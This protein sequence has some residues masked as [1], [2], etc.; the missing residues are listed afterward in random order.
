MSS[1]ALAAMLANNPMTTLPSSAAVTRPA[2]SQMQTF[3]FA[4]ALTQLDSPVSESKAVLKSAEARFAAAAATEKV[5][6]LKL[7]V[8]QR[9]LELEDLQASDGAASKVV[10]KAERLLQK[11]VA[12]LEKAE[13]DAA[14]KVA[15]AKAAMT[16]EQR[17][18]E[19]AAAKA[20]ATAAAKKR[21][22]EKK[23]VA[24]MQNKGGYKK[25]GFAKGGTKK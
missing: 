9:T 21:A 12:A 6:E 10:S 20:K 14:K 25:A 7:D 8:V 17:A 3:S 2:I 22:A 19:E 24:D 15:A 18:A 1:I 11:S 16:P 5:S 4:T 13:A 23:K